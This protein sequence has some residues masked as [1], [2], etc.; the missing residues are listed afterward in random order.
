MGCVEEEAGHHTVPLGF[1]L[2]LIDLH[3]L[4]SH[5]TEVIFARII[6]HGLI[7]ADIGY[8]NLQE[9]LLFSLEIAKRVDEGIDLVLLCL[10]C[11]I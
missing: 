4:P 10:I 1:L 5:H 6:S 9:S 2:L 8:F 3:K 11:V 7:G